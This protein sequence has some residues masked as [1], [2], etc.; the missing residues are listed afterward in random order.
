MMRNLRFVT[1]GHPG[2]CLQPSSDPANLARWAALTPYF[3]VG[4]GVHLLRLR[5]ACNRLGATE[6]QLAGIV[7]DGCLRSVPPASRL[8]PRASC[9]P[10][11]ASCLVPPASRLPPPSPSPSPQPPASRTNARLSLPVHRRSA[12]GTTQSCSLWTPLWAVLLLRAS[13]QA[14]GAATR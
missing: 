4:L 9:L 10:P 13:C 8:P 7:T 2:V 11:P 3:R 1:F 6:A 14:P 5:G 12:T